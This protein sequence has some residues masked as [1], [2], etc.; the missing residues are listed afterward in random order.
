[1]QFLPLSIL[2]SLNLLFLFLLQW[3]PVSI[4][5][6]GLETDMLFAALVLPQLLA[7]ILGSNLVQ[8]LVPVIIEQD[9]SLSKGIFGGIAI[10]VAFSSAVLCITLA[11]SA[12]FVTKVLYS[13]YSSANQ[14]VISDL[15]SVSLIGSFFNLLV[16]TYSAS[17]Y[18][19][20]KQLLIEIFGLL[21]GMVAVT[22]M[23]LFATVGQ[24]E[25]TIQ[26]I[27]LRW[28]IC[29]GLL[30]FFS[31]TQSISYQ[32]GT[33][34]KSIFW[35]LKN[36]VLGGSIY[37]SDLLFDRYLSSQAMSGDLTLLHIIQLVYGA[38]NSLLNKVFLAPNL[39]ELTKLKVS[40]SQDKFATLF[41]NLLRKVL[42]LNIAVFICL[43]GATILS[44]I[45]PSITIGD[46]SIQRWSLVALLCSGVIIGGTF[47]G[48]FSVKYYSIGD[49]LTPTK[50]GLFG[51]GIGL[52]LKVIGFK[53]IGFTGLLIA[54]SCYYL[55]N[56]TIFF[57][58]HKRDKLS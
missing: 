34:L 33:A 32:C 23:L 13:S 41:S 29:F 36:L 19:Q 55:L 6:A 58:L 40:D 4:L 2:A 5:G 28:I 14:Q 11:Y 46:T 9:K 3:L 31:G 57:V 25:Q 7:T 47:G 49:T 30:F 12:P 1:M 35:R 37:K 15:I 8:V 56:V 44:I 16:F 21:S 18:V 24:L 50:V 22:Y 17:F 27:N 51:F 48:V 10:V 20:K 26:S 54:I 43:A 42:W 38:L 53:L 52:M 39:P 45:V